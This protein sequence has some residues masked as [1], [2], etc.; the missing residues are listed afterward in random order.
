MTTIKILIISSLLSLNVFS[1]D[2][3]SLRREHLLK[4]ITI[5]ASSVL[6]HYVAYVT[7][8]NNKNNP[9]SYLYTGV[10]FTFGLTLNITATNHFIKYHK[11]KKKSLSL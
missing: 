2:T 1:Q 5:S 4:G 10:W 7:Y 3:L 9:Q 11:L 6:P 8:I